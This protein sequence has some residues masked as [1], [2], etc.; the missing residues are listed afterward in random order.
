[1]VL[2]TM[3]AAIGILTGSQILVLRAGTGRAHRPGPAATFFI[4][5][6]G[7]YSVLVALL[8]GIAGLLSLATAR[9]P[10]YSRLASLSD[11][12]TASRDHGSCRP[13]RL[14]PGAANVRWVAGV[15]TF[16]GHG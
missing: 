15:H 9:V 3:I 6:P 8:A 10:G 4:S 14:S 5:H 11:Q 7:V 1:M 12:G 16:T 2:A 13:L